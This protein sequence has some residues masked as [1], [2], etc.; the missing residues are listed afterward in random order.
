[1]RDG[2]H[3][4]QENFIETLVYFHRQVLGCSV[5]IFRALGAGLA[6]I[7]ILLYPKHAWVHYIDDLGYLCS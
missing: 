3:Q 7:H 2:L 1:M 6:G 5:S 4:H